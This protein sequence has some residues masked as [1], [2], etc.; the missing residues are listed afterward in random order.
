MNAARASKPSAPPA[1]ALRATAG[2]REWSS[3]NDASERS[4]ASHAIG[5]SRRS[6]ERER[7]SGS[8]AFAKATAD[9]AEALAEGCRGAKPLGEDK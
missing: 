1:S 4:E 9:T 6:G 3:E 5:A 7:V 2:K 8:S